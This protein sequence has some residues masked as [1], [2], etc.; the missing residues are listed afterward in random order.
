MRSLMGLTSILGGRVTLMQH[1]HCPMTLTATIFLS[2]LS[3]TLPVVALAQEAPKKSPGK[4]QSSTSYVYTPA[5]TDSLGTAT[6]VSEYQKLLDNKNYERTTAFKALSINGGERVDREESERSW[7]VS[8]SQYQV[9]R[10][11]RT[12]DL[13]GRLATEPLIK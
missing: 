9:E 6:K 1:N 5:S 11:I 4:E 12:P 7:K 10:T 2:F 8:E 3:F 13:N